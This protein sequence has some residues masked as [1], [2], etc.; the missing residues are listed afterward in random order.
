MLSQCAGGDGSPEFCGQQKCEYSAMSCEFEAALRERNCDV[1]LDAEGGTGGGVSRDRSEPVT[2]VGAGLCVEVVRAHPWWVADD[3]IESTGGVG[4]AE[5]RAEVKGDGA[6]VVEA[7]QC[8]TVLADQVAYGCK[9]SALRCG[10][11]MACSEQG[12]CTCELEQFGAFALQRID[13]VRGDLLGGVAFRI[14][15]AS[16]AGVLTGT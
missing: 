3:D 8:A 1:G 16:G 6:A 9:A 10:E 15:D 12:S 5:V 14:I 13:V 11:T 2:E 4:V 7:A